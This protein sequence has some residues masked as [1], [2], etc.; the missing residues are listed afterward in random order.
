[1]TDFGFLV[2][3][4][5]IIQR[6]IRRLLTNKGEW[7]PFPQYGAGLRQRV[8]DVL[9]LQEAIRIRS[10][11]INQIL[12]EP[13]VAA[14]PPPKVQVQSVPNG[15][16]VSLLFYTVTFLPISFAFNS[17]APNQITVPALNMG[18]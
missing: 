7:I 1:M 4:P 13:D 3:R 10:D 2:D 17:A 12:M 15:V 16:L 18:S 8:N 11:I 14:Q 6:V 5:E 9:S